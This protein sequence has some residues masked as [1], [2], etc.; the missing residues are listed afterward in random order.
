MRDEICPVL[1]KGSR[2]PKTTFKGR[3]IVILCGGDAFLPSGAVLL[4]RLKDLG[5]DLPVQIWYCGPDEMSDVWRT[6]YSDLY[7]GVKFC[8]VFDYFS[9]KLYSAGMFKDRTLPD[10]IL[11]GRRWYLKPV[12]IINSPYKEV[13]FLDADIVPY[14][15]PATWFEWDCFKEADVF[16]P[17]LND[18]DHSFPWKYFG[19]EPRVCP[20][21]ES[22]MMLI[23]KERA[24]RPLQL[25]LWL[26]SRGEEFPEVWGD[27]E[28]PQLSWWVKKVPFVM[29]KKRPR[30]YTMCLEQHHPTT[31]EPIL[32]HRT[33]PG[34]KWKLAGKSAPVGHRDE[35]LCFTFLEDLTKRLFLIDPSLIRDIT[36]LHKKFMTTKWRIHFGGALDYPIF[37]IDGTVTGQWI[38]NYIKRWDV[39]ADGLLVLEPNGSMCMSQVLR[40]VG[41]NLWVSTHCVLQPEV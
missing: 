10:S 39:T 24:W 22:G 41:E 17:D 35:D 8:D 16:M 28:F 15:N 20:G 1:T 26:C 38:H 31:D 29:S 30:R 23:D 6:I 27:K 12:A 9:S 14:E 18:L 32:L 5:C 3:G 34:G 36:P 21:Q 33:S 13:L 2:Y 11:E 7:P 19:L 37:N 40:P 4:F 25:L